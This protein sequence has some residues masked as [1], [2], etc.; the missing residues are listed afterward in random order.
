MLLRALII[1]LFASQLL[2]P[3][4]L[5]RR[6]YTIK[7]RTI[8]YDMIAFRPPVQITPDNGAL[9]Q[10]TAINCVRLFWSRLS[11]LDIEGASQLY[12]D[13]QR[14]LDA[15]TKYR[16]RVGE[17][18]F[19]EMHSKIFGSTRFTHELVI[20]AQHGLVSD[21]KLG[22][23]LL[24]RVRGGIFFLE[25]PELGKLSQDATDLIA[26]VNAFGDGKLKFD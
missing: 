13:P 7:G 19:R 20:G 2:M 4:G 3:Q 6:T 16:Q 5:Q 23:L 8:A 21:N 10:D 25:S 18:T 14:E 17:E 15:R 26:L 9:N 1:C 11:K 22:T 24:F 12:I